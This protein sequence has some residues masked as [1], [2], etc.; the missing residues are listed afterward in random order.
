MADEIRDVP[1]I[2][3]PSY[4]E[5]ERAALRAMLSE[6]LRRLDV[7]G[8]RDEPLRTIARLTKEREDTVA[9]L[10][11]VCRDHGDNEW[12][13]SEYLADVVEKHLARHLRTS[14]DGALREALN[15][16]LDL[17]VEYM[18]DSVGPSSRAAEETD[19]RIIAWR[20]LARGS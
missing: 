4:L 5:G 11:S 6:V 16:A 7:H 19:P 12:E 20:K 1:K 18:N 9:A 14:S 15:G 2:H 8:S 10:R 17:L 3:E 13:P